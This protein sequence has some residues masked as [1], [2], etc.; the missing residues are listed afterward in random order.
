[1]TDMSP[2]LSALYP[3]PKFW[4]GGGIAIMGEDELAPVGAIK[5]IHNAPSDRMNRVE[6]GNAVIMIVEY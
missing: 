2:R 4:A 3:A 5:M 6:A 1:M